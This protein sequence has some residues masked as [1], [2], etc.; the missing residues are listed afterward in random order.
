MDK[1]ARAPERHIP[2]RPIAPEPDILEVSVGAKRKAD[3]PLEEEEENEPSAADRLATAPLE[4]VVM[5]AKKDATAEMDDERI[6]PWYSI[7]DCNDDQGELLWAMAA[8][9]WIPTGCK[10]LH[11]I[12]E[13]GTGK[14]FANKTLLRVC[15]SGQMWVPT[16]LMIAGH[17]LGESPTL[18]RLITEYA[19]TAKDLARSII[20]AAPT[21][22]AAQHYKPDGRTLHSAF[23]ITPA[24]SDALTKPV[25]DVSARSV[26]TKH[27][28]DL[29]RL[30]TRYRRM[31]SMSAE[32]QDVVW[33]DDFPDTPAGRTLFAVFVDI[34][35]ISMVSPRLA[36][37]IEELARKVRG[38]ERFF[39][40]MVPLFMG[41]LR[42]LRDVD[43]SKAE[44][45]FHKTR[46]YTPLHGVIAPRPLQLP[47]LPQPVATPSPRLH[48]LWHDRLQFLT[49]LVN[50]RHAKDRTLGTIAHQ[51]GNGQGCTDAQIN[52][53]M[54]RMDT[55]QNCLIQRK[56]EACRA[57]GVPPPLR[58]YARVPTVRRV[59]QEQLAALSGPVF[60]PEHVLYIE[61]AANNG[62]YRTCLRRHVPGE[63]PSTANSAARLLTSMNK[64]FVL[65]LTQ[66]DVGRL[67][68][69]CTAMTKDLVDVT[70]ILKPGIPVRL[71]TNIDVSRGL[72]NGARAIL[73]RMLG[74]VG[75][76]SI[77]GR[78]FTPTDHS[79]K[80]MV[81]VTLNRVV[82][83]TKD[84]VCPL[85]SFGALEEYDQHRKVDA[86]CTSV[87]NLPRVLLQLVSQYCHLSLDLKTAT[88]PL[89]RC[90]GALVTM[91]G[92][93]GRTLMVPYRPSKRD[94]KLMSG[95]V[96]RVCCI[97][98]P[99]QP[100]FA[101]TIHTAQGMT[102]DDVIVSLDGCFEDGQAYTA[103]TRAKT[104]QGLIFERHGVRADMFRAGTDAFRKLFGVDNEIIAFCKWPHELRP[105]LAKHPAR[106]T[107]MRFQRD[108]LPVPG[109]TVTTTTLTKPVLKT[110]VPIDPPPRPAAAAA[111]ATVT[112]KPNVFAPPPPPGAD[113]EFSL[114]Q[115]LAQCH[116]DDD[117]DC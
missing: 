79:A 96:I 106:D 56:L 33:M 62:I 15:M 27:I 85:H 72:C 80:S 78:S 43:S 76:S 109:A 91:D 77:P 49:W 82:R 108:W 6:P 101:R 14:T 16:A 28:T 36:I 9:G 12:G 90:S 99:W 68:T 24:V 51:L 65:K 100:D 66:S 89:C 94:V 25:H 103:I 59:N 19:F 35:E 40:G 86:A 20:M 11:V 74:D 32:H 107:W 97:T 47:P 18:T 21:G 39:G 63:S 61:H 8:I 41:D 46:A 83:K 55:P 60:A 57:R 29:A 73:H 111:A 3:L 87:T 88:S 116:D 48:V 2:V 30:A 54:S 92:A 98:A 93:D 113:E 53:L 7:R 44:Q 70:A 104:I 84:E 50:V 13:A 17:A 112:R 95:K 105:A 38:N 71:C 5:T 75:A 69:V 4:M 37:H 117:F 67:T 45:A 31:Q 58:I 23:G 102:C 81:D 42:Q 34:D 52:V 1:W 64:P 114:S 115:E 26:L 110:L 22:S 10:G